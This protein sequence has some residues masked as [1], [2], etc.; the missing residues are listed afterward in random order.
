L[1]DIKYIVSKFPDGQQNIELDPYYKDKKP[2]GIATRINNWQDLELVVA[3]VAALRNKGIKEISLYV[4]YLVGA[5]S[6]RAF[7]KKGVHYLKQVIGPVINS[8]N[9]ENVYV[10][11]PHSDVMEACINNLSKINMDE[12]Y[13]KVHYVLIREGFDKYVMVSPDNGARKRVEAAAKIRSTQIITCN[14]ERDSKGNII[15]TEV[16]LPITRP[17]AYV[18]I[19]DICDGGRTFTEIAKVIK[20]ADVDNKVILVVT[21]GIFSKGLKLENIDHIISTNSYSDL[22]ISNAN[23]TPYS[24][25]DRLSIANVM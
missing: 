22:S 14:K 18:I 5:R 17:Q 12:F 11:D 13:Q 20:N 1:T 9:F 23:Y 25:F 2:V 4:P 24:V 15:R 10:L 3:S 8:L 19:D 6:D 21:H 7:I 16:P